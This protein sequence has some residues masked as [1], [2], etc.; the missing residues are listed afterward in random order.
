MGLGTNTTFE[1]LTDP[2]MPVTVWPGVGYTVKLNLK[3]LSVWSEYGLWVPA[4]LDG[5]LI[6][7]H[8]YCVA[9]GQSVSSLSPNVLMCKAEVIVITASLGHW[10]V[11]GGRASFR[12]TKNVSQLID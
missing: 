5:M 4:N 10:L 6:L 7:S 9:L 8:T 1:F 12:G 3:C 2:L 11:T